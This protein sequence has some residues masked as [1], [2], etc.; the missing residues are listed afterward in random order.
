MYSELVV[1]VLLDQE[2]LPTAF[3][4]VLLNW[5]QKQRLNRDLVDMKVM[6]RTSSE[7]EKT[8]TSSE[9]AALTVLKRRGSVRVETQLS[10]FTQMQTWET[11]E[12]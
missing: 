9:D 1:A 4:S 10:Y 11:E 8:R 7:V 12:M 3:V 5:L 2:K 6:L